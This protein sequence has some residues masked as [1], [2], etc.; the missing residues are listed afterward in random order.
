MDIESLSKKNL[1]VSEIV[2]WCSIFVLFIVSIVGNYLCRSYSVILRGIVIV[3]IITVAMYIVSLTKIGKLLVI[4]GQE[5]LV[6]L[7]QVVWPTYR[8]GLN[9]TLIIVAVTI[10]V[11]LVLWGLDAI[12]VNVISFGL[13]L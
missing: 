6:E 7:K 5:S 11:S 12:I 8:D 9:T 13:R 4:F 10:I 1:S 2:K 3:L